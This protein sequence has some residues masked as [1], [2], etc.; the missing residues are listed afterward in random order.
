MNLEI[1]IQMLRR[2][3]RLL[4][5]W[6]SSGDIPAIERD[7]ACDL[8]RR[9]YDDILFSDK[10]AAAA[11]EAS[12]AEN[13]PDPMNGKAVDAADTSV[14]AVAA[15][16]DARIADL[17]SPVGLVGL[18][19]SGKPVEEIPEELPEN[20]EAVAEPAVEPASV[21]ECTEDFAEETAGE[22]AEKS[23]VEES[24]PV[25]VP[26]VKQAVEEASVEDPAEEPVG[27]V[28]PADASA[29]EDAPVEGPVE[30]LAEEN[31][32]VETP[33][34]ENASEEVSA[35]GPVGDVSIE[36]LDEDSAEGIVPIGTLAEKEPVEEDAPVEAFAEESSE[37]IASIEVPVE[38]PVGEDASVE[39]PAEKT[40]EENVPIGTPAEEPVEKDAS[41]ETPVEEVAEEEIAVEAFGDFEFGEAGDAVEEPGDAVPSAEVV[42]APDPD[43][44]VDVVID[45]VFEVFADDDEEA[46]EMD[47]TEETEEAEAVDLV[48]AVNVVE[49]VEAVGS[50]EDTEIAEEMEVVEEFETEEPEET[51]LGQP[52]AAPTEIRSVAA[53]VERVAEPGR[54]S[55]SAPAPAETSAEEA[56]ANAAAS[57]TETLEEMAARFKNASGRRRKSRRAFMSLYDDDETARRGERNDQLELSDWGIEPSDPSSKLRHARELFGLPV[58]DLDTPSEPAPQPA[59]NPATESESIGAAAATDDEIEIEVLDFMGDDDPVQSDR[60][61]NSA[62][63][64]LIK[65]ATKPTPE[66][67]ATPTRSTSR[68]TVISAREERNDAD[69]DLPFDEAIVALDD[70]DD[71]LSAVSPFDSPGHPES[72]E[73]PE[74]SESSDAGAVSFEPIEIVEIADGGEE[75]SEIEKNETQ[76]T[77]SSEV[78]DEPTMS[79]AAAPAASAAEPAA[80][81]GLY[82]REEK[83]E[84]PAAT[85]VLGE[86]MGHDGPTVGDSLGRRPDVAGWADVS[87]DLNRAISVGDR[88]VLLR[89]LFDGDQALCD[90]TLKRLSAFDDLD[91]CMIWITENFAWNANSEGA[92]LIMGLLERKL[93]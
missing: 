65:P 64:S 59:D 45:P 84:M 73:H 48:D 14:D 5:G 93:G 85:T 23:A 72:P 89:D 58:D 57:N 7:L 80:V 43:A 38:A 91:D 68:S 44:F 9:A 24:A 31:S 46:E 62:A 79:G 67:T 74:D 35:E 90:R 92:K 42:A 69:D 39:K 21:E 76:H 33:A 88:F 63:E 47:G 82:G 18:A 25:E 16:G 52:V 2:I 19:P 30:K 40:A 61:A 26:V 60:G 4:D 49:A 77:D 41:V 83:P 3:E 66:P 55:A 10:Y 29:E 56:P 86:V 51:E 11:S 22:S 32:P 15:T 71:T 36:K 50:A 54:E 81:R 8:L 28:L 37:E 78:A 1:T 12:L 6:R 53:P 13:T 70:P 75:V 17:A 20:A 87:E 34:E 27:E